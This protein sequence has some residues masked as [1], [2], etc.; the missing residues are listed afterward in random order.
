M[1]ASREKVGERFV[2][3]A[4]PMLTQNDA[5]CCP[6]L[7]RPLNDRCFT[8][9]GEV[10][11]FSLPFIHQSISQ[12][13]TP[14]ELYAGFRRGAQRKH[15]VGVLRRYSPSGRSLCL[16]LLLLLYRSPIPAAAAA[17]CT[18]SMRLTF[19]WR[20]SCRTYFRHLY[21]CVY[22][23]MAMH[24]PACMRPCTCGKVW[25]L[26]AVFL[27]SVGRCAQSERKT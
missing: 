27:V 19:S 5:S 26:L 25:G 10:S 16:L 3:L 21:V 4:D 20:W 11:R 6:T 7:T 12:T 9:K 13:G 15:K 17:S 8:S 14:C 23:A 22:V 24:V 18:D 2:S 1:V